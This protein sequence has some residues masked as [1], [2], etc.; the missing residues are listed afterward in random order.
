MTPNLPTHEKGS[1][2]NHSLMSRIIRDKN[3]HGIYDF[4]IETPFPLEF[5]FIKDFPTGID[6]WT[7]II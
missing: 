3:F 5:I 6:T 1:G 4:G 7:N 2:V